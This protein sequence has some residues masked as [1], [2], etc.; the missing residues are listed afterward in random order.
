MGIADLWPILSDAFDPRILFPVFLTRFLQKH[1]R[2]PRLAIDAYM[3]MFWSQIPS[4]ETLDPAITRRIIRNFMAKLWYLVQH[5][6]SFVVVFDG[7]HKP[8]KLRHGHV[9]DAPDSCS[10]DEMLHYFLGLHTSTYSEGLRLVESIKKILTRNRIDWVQAPAEA[11]AECAWLQRL[12]VVDY[13]VSDDSDSLVFGASQVLRLFNRVKYYDAEGEP[14]QSST[15]YY[16]TPVHMDKV[17]RVT[18]LTRQRLV[19]IAVLRG[20]DYST[21]TENVGIVRAKDISLCG[22]NVLLRSPRKKSQDF[23]AFPDFTK[24]FCDTFVD[25]TRAQR[26]LADPY[27][28][29]KPELDRLESLQAFNKHLDAF[30]RKDHKSVFGRA[31]NFT[32]E[33]KVDDYYALLYFFPFVNTRFFK[34]TPHSVSFGEPS[35]IPRD[36][37]AETFISVPRINYNLSPRPIGRLVID[38][39]GQRFEPAIPL[40]NDSVVL[41]RERKF[42]LKAFALKLVKH[43]K[44]WDQI[45]LARLRDFEGVKLAALKF[46][47]VALNEAVY[48]L[49]PD[50][51][52]TETAEESSPEADEPEPG[53]PTKEVTE[54][55]A[56]VIVVFVTLES[57]LHISPAFVEKFYRTS[58]QNSPTKRKAP[59]QKT[60][61]DLLWPSLLPT[62]GAAPTQS[63]LSQQNLS[64]KAMTLVDESRLSPTRR[65][66]SISP[67]NSQRR[68][69]PRR[70]K[71]HLH[72]L[73]PGQSTL[74]SFIAAQTTGLAEE[75]ALLVLSDDEDLENVFLD[76]RT[77]SG[78][79][80]ILQPLVSSSMLH[81]PLLLP[82]LSPTKRRRH[83]SSTIDGLP[84]KREK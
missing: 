81:P 44:F 31:T 9:P 16:V 42:N 84:I 32:G 59:P 61:L 47:R 22:S 53:L 7:N 82:E 39:D 34:F 56:K 26:P 15:D 55:P 30:L 45:S 11:E 69:S 54:D 63:C 2:P 29:L 38:K 70:G 75:N 62:K 71:L 20:G 48:L 6:V 5:N 18:D 74:N 83:V 4:D 50:Y 21:G 46:E 52:E 14:V 49:R 60:T 37:L 1:G 79:R 57:V 77:L 35:H 33:I 25:H 72:E 66:G 27:Y 8:G 17:V 43:P 36:L 40:D 64:P 3:F 78:K 67:T 51:E 24:R 76:S 73:L 12:G 65:S 19:F 13:V 23:G 68:R 41:P 80:P 58:Q 10:Y 28:A